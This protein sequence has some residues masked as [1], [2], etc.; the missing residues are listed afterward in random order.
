MDNK[1]EKCNL[2]PQPSSKLYIKGSGYIFISPEVYF[3]C[4]PRDSYATGAEIT[5]IV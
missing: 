2:Y 1:I 3:A 5:N 4:T